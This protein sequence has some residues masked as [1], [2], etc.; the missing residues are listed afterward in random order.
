M[1]DSASELTKLVWSLSEQRL[2]APMMIVVGEVRDGRTV[3]LPL[4]LRHPNTHLA[5]IR[6]ALA[7]M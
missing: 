3:A 5:S 4:A 6:A 1:R 2:S 7:A